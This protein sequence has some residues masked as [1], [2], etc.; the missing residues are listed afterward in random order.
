MDWLMKRLKLIVRSPAQDEYERRHARVVASRAGYDYLRRRSQEGMISEHAWQKLSQPLK[1]Q[2]DLLIEKVKQVMTSEPDVEAEELD[3]AFRE[4]LRAQRSALSGLLRDG[5]ISEE[6]YSQ[7]V[8]EV[9]EALMEENPSAKLFE[10]KPSGK[11]EASPD[12]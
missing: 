8:S 11:V 5:V 2:N 1:L 9:D 6:T 10:K 3:T 7:L 12:I 4:A